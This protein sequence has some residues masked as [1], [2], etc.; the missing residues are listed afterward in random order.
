LFFNNAGTHTW[1]GATGSEVWYFRRLHVCIPDHPVAMSKCGEGTCVPWGAA[2][3][4]YRRPNFRIGSDPSG[5]RRLG[6]TENGRLG[7]LATWEMCRAVLV[8][9]SK[10][11][12][13]LF[14][15]VDCEHS[16]YA[17]RTSMYF[18]EYDLLFH[19]GHSHLLAEPR[20]CMTMVLRL[21]TVRNR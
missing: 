5:L 8:G 12:S 17:R 15:R 4:E 10:N 16:C 19:V 14:R 7:L 13:M 9:S 20:D 6:R 18:S 2:S 1:L 11:H 21:A 3:T